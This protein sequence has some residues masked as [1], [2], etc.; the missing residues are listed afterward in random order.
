VFDPED[1]EAGLA[2]DYV[3][4]FLPE[5]V[6]AWAISWSR[7]GRRHCRDQFGAAAGGSAMS[8]Y[9]SAVAIGEL[10]KAQAVLYAHPAGLDA[11]CL[12]CGSGDPCP[13]RRAA[14]SVFDRFGQLPRRYPG[15]SR[16]ERF[17]PTRRWL[18]RPAR[19]RTPADGL[20]GPVLPAL[21]APLAD[22]Q[23]ILTVERLTP[24]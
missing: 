23:L 9:L 5:R 24:H 19:R 22:G 18:P 13:A 10:R 2:G 12:A 14:L 8:L 17:A 6:L 11:R 16:P 15:A 4:A 20:V 3:I 1:I 21:A 7:P